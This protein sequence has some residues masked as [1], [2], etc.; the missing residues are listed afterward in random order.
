[1][2][3][4]TWLGHASVLIETQDIVDRVVARTPLGRYGVPED[5]VGG[6]VYLASDAASFVTGHGLMVDGAYTAA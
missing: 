1:M 3:R 4:L 2:T 5:I 6:A